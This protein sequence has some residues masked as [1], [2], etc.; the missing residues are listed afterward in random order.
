MTKIRFCCVSQDSQQKSQQNHIFI[1]YLFCFKNTKMWFR[2]VSQQKSQL[3]C[4]SIVYLRESGRSQEGRGGDKVKGEIFLSRGQIGYF[5]LVKVPKAKVVGAN[6]S[7]LSVLGYSQFLLCRPNKT[8]GYAY[9][10]GLITFL[11]CLVQI[12]IWVD[13]VF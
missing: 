5:T 8:L 11:P 10:S 12:I 3:N 13:Y 4:V 6:S 2:C 7:P 9:F 1:V